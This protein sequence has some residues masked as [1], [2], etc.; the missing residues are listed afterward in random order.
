MDNHVVVGGHPP[1]DIRIVEAAEENRCY[2]VDCEDVGLR[3]LPNV[4]F[5]L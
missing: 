3:L 5:A 4:Y 2:A 1:Q